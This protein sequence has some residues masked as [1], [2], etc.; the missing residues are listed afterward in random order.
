MYQSI[1]QLF[2]GDMRGLFE[3]V[4]RRE[5]FVNE[6][7]LRC[8]KP[9][10][11]VEG[12]RE[13]FLDKSGFY[14]EVLTE[15]VLINREELDGIIQHLCHYSLYAYEE[16][17][18]QGYIT[19]A[20]G[21]RIGM[22][23][24]V[25]LEGNGQIRTIKHICGINI[26]VSHQMKGVA[27]AV[28][29]YLYEMGR[30]KNVLIVSPPGCGKTTLLRDIIRSVSD[31]NTYA[32][33]MT[34]GVVD[35]RSEIAGAFLGQPQNDVGIRTDVLDAC[36]KVSGMMLLLRA[37]SPKVIAID[38]LGSVEEMAAVKT[39]IACGSKIVATMHGNDLQDIRRRAGMEQ[40]LKESCF[41]LILLLGK[42]GGRCV[43]K[44]IFEESKSGEWTCKR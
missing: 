43:I 34:V 12:G 19:V 7:R 30:M 23:G 36:P 13:Y 20:G 10:L 25:V 17:L 1:L 18:K 26:R 5:A 42:E 28:L 22:A 37:M 32:K 8:E 40:L 44:G 31:G 39:I 15:A 4:A 33:G 9:I 35:E 6:I 27:T 3:Y 38:E 41:E 14:T 21:H 11:V 24:Q 2:P 29:P 16:E